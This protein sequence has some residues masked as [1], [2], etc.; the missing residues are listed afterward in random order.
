MALQSRF[1]GVKSVKRIKGARQRL[2]N[3]NGALFAFYRNIRERKCNFNAAFYRTF[4]GVK[5]AL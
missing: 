2:S 5:M 3:E 4:K 1:I